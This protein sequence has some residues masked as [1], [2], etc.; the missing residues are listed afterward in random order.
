MPPR[1][2]VRWR[3]LGAT[4]CALAVLVG[5]GS[6]PG[7]ADDSAPRADAETLAAAR[8]IDRKTGSTFLDYYEQ[9]VRLAQRHSAYPDSFRVALDAL[10]GSH[11]TDEEWAAW[12]APYTEDPYPV[13]ERLE[14]VITTLGAPPRR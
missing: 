8:A 5:A 9:V 11:L 7:C 3:G 14:E 4:A 6:L 2:D 13:T 12:V 1:P 10:P